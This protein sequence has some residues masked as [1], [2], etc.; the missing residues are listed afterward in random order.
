[1][2]SP[3]LPTPFG[4]SSARPDRSEHDHVLWLPVLAVAQQIA[5]VWW[6]KGPRVL[7]LNEEEQLLG[8]G[9]TVFFLLCCGSRTRPGQKG[10]FENDVRSGDGRR[11]H[12]R[13]EP[14]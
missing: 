8:H 7:H 11:E 14:A 4:G 1:V 2:A 13:K 5:S 10:R 9:F 3:R 12:C 6:S